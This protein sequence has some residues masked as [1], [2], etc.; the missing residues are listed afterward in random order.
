MLLW[1]KPVSNVEEWLSPCPFCGLGPKHAG[2]STHEVN[3]LNLPPRDRIQLPYEP[4]LQLLQGSELHKPDIG[5][6]PL[7]S[8]P[9]VTLEVSVVARFV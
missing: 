9:G 3:H 2:V 5:Q 1:R 7:L 4:L 8:E 6:A